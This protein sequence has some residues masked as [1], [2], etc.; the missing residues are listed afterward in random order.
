[1]GEDIGAERNVRVQGAGGADAE[2]VQGLV[3]GLHLA[4][5]E[6]DIRQGVEFGH[7]N[8]NIVGADAMRQDGDAFPVPLSGD[9][10]EFAGSVAELDLVQQVRDHVHAAGVA[11][12]DDVVGQFF[13]LQ[14]DMEGGAVAIDNEFRFRDSHG[15]S[16]I[17]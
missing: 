17:W 5:G 12:E 3:H 15:C 8:V 16:I 7:D 9:G 10:N 2:D 4:G 11:H 13:R 6:I 14:M 1:M